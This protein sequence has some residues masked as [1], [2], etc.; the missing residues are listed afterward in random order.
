MS[1]RTC[2]HVQPSPN[3]HSALQPTMARRALDVNANGTR[4]HNREIVYARVCVIRIRAY[5]RVH[6][7]ALQVCLVRP[8]GCRLCGAYAVAVGVI[9]HELA[10]ACSAGGPYSAAQRSMRIWMGEVP[11]WGIGSR[12]Q[13]AGCRCKAS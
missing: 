7:A 1:V 3:Q 9:A 13:G 11:L 6:G 8:P 10:V 12:V 4:M 5:V 2:V